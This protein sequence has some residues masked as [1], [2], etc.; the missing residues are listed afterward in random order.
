MTLS[1]KVGQ[2]FIFGFKGETVSPEMQKTIATLKPGGFILFGRN[3]KS[4]SQIAQ[5]NADLQEISLKRNGTPLFLA[6]D[7]EGGSVTRIK[8]S[9]PLPSAYTIGGTNEPT[10]AFQA[11][12]VTGEMLRVL[13]FNM[14]LAPVLDMTD[15]NLDSFISARSYSSSPNLISS[16][17]LAFAQ[18]LAEA[19]I[20][21]V[22]KHFPGHGPILLDTHQMTPS[23]PLSF[24][25]LMNSELIPFTEFAS[26]SIPSG[27]MVAHIVYPEVD[28]SKNPATYSKKLI[29]GLLLD[30]LKFKGLVMTDDIEMGGAASLKNIEDRAVAAVTAGNDLI[31]VGWTPSQQTR[32]VNGVVKAVKSGKISIARINKSVEKILAMKSQLSQPQNRGLASTSSQ[33]SKLS[34]SQNISAQF[35]KIQYRSVFN[36]IIARYFKPLESR[37]H[38]ITSVEKIVV[39]SPL[40]SFHA[41]FNKVDKSQK[42]VNKSDL[43]SLTA[44]PKTLWV[45]HVP[46]P[47]ALEG[48]R[49]IPFEMQKSTIVVSSHPK[50]KIQNPDT[51]L[52]VVETYSHSPMLGQFTAEAIQK[53][54]TNS[55]TASLFNLPSSFD[56]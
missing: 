13:G 19:Q 26:S 50:L 42:V 8:T 4:L 34:L 28:A 15:E 37:T 17:G 45:Y 39:I 14:N 32:A 55:Q 22:A 36:D 18:G 24:S 6:V 48:L 23:R 2:L 53:M 43:R 46:S 40:P 54:L 11:G 33:K 5:L 51:F 41:S 20:L 10:L 30:Q 25:T 35:K 27:I 47:M 31:M 9:P 3:I 29:Q 56:R 21:P 52:S 7:Q 44:S 16:M 1:Q 49:K 12:K 38:V